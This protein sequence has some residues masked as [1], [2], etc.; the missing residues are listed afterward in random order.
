MKP[1]V[2]KMVACSNLLSFPKSKA[3]ARQFFFQFLHLLEVQD[4]ELNL[5]QR[6]SPRQLMLIFEDGHCTSMNLLT[7]LKVMVTKKTVWIAGH[8][9]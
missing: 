7:C 3:I 8:D 2:E 1:W 5:S 9:G 4:G 6:C